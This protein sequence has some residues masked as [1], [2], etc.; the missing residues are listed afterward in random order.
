MTKNWSVVRVL[1]DRDAALC[2]A[3]SVVSGFGTSALWLASG[4]WVKDLT[5]SNGL[6]ALCTLALW[7]PTLLA[8]LLGSLADRTRRRPLLVAFNLGPAALLLTVAAVDSPDRLWLLFAVLFL[9]GAASVVVDA[10]ESALVAAAVAPEL[11]GDFNGL[12]MTFTE[13]MKLVA[14]PTGA[15]VYAAY[16]G[17]GVALLDAATFVCAAGLYGCV[18]VREE[19]PRGAAGHWRAH[20]AE[21]ARFLWAHP[22]LRPLVVA[23]GTTML[24]AGLGA[25]LLYAVV[26]GLGRSPAYAGALY[27]AQ[28]A[29][30]IVAG[31]L[32][33]PGLR[34]LGARRFA[35]CGIAL[36]AVA[37]AAQAVPSEPVA[38]MCSAAIGAG[39]PCAL[40]AALTA[41][42]QQTPD[43][44]LGRVT[45]TA[46]TLLYA[47]NAIGL[48]AGAGLVELLPYQVLLATLGLAR[49]TAVLPLLRA[50]ARHG[51]GTA[52]AAAAPAPDAG[53]T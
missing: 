34:R 51:T 48:A 33:G 16:G 3:V 44:L 43:A 47:P 4:V 7:A 37:V 13:G 24:F 5:G 2:L 46:G 25:P 15:V 38:L 6:A 12:R 26:E 31:L 45:A 20:T 32:S 50:T 21:G 18:R 29:G 42:Q 30:S 39:L 35:G 8:P 52:H 19:R 36:T 27:A 17:Q 1:R 9:Y 23:G 49:L 28:G 40:I 41:V 22:G 10:A 11:L 53:R 14:P